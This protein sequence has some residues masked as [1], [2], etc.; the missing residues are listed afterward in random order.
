VPM[1]TI[2]KGI[3]PFVAVEIAF[4][5]ILVAFPQLALFL[6]RLMR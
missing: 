1:E 5:I 6:P 2:F 3:M 4:V